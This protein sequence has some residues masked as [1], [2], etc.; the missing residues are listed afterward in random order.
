MHAQGEGVKSLFSFSLILIKLAQSPGIP[1]SVDAQ[2][3]TQR[4][5]VTCKQPE[6]TSC[7]LLALQAI[8]LINNRLGGIKNHLGIWDRFSEEMQNR[9]A[10][11]ILRFHLQPNGGIPHE[12]LVLIRMRP[13]ENGRFGFNVK[14]QI[15]PTRS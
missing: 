11:T 10:V 3:T 7:C 14:V 8:Y 4:S 9:E 2:M 1:I 5:L 12:N 6:L 13:D 15:K